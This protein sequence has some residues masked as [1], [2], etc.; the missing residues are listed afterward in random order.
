MASDVKQCF[1]KP[2]IS[3]TD[4]LFFEKLPAELRNK[5]YQ[6]VHTYER[7]SLVDSCEDSK[8]GDVSN[9]SLRGYDRLRGYVTIDLKAIKI[10]KNNLAF[11]C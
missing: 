9:D 8:D 5:I 7:N 1:T 4:S 2:L 3:Q 11:T 6:L 10:P